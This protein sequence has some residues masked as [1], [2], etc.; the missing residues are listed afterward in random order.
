MTEDRIEGRI[1]ARLAELGLVLP[2]PAEPTFHYVPVTLHAG[3]AWVSGQLPKV[4]GEVRVFGKVGAEVSVAQAQE[5]ARICA[6]QGLACLKAAIGDLGQVARVL[7]V[8]GFVAS[9][10]GFGGQ[11]GVI[12]AASRL[13]TEVFGE[14][15]RHARSA[16]GVAELPRNAPVEIEMVVAVAEDAAR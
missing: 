8:T 11:P 14:R 1:E 15:G 7:K 10:P 2:A 9:A 5:L 3:V 6:L 4:D 13:L 12:D 16:V